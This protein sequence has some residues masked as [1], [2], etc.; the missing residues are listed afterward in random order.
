MVASG[1]TS[2]AERPPAAQS[3]S[4]GAD[5]IIGETRFYDTQAKTFIDA[6]MVDPDR[7]R[8]GDEQAGPA[9]L[10]ATD[11]TVVLPSGATAVASPDGYLIIELDSS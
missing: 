3:P 6:P 7:M 4:A 10:V 1:L 8:P 2:P 11:T 5:A 9:L